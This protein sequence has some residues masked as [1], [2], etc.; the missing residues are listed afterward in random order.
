MCKERYNWHDQEERQRLHFNEKNV[1]MAKG[2]SSINEQLN[3]F[4]EQG[5]TQTSGIYEKNKLHIG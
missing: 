4:R 1:T 5:E 2:R 3:S